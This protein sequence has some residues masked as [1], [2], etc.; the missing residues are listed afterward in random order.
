[1]G[2]Q[3]GVNVIIILVVTKGFSGTQNQPY[4]SACSGTGPID[5]TQCGGSVNLEN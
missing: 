5:S 4:C 3:A 2:T 1:M